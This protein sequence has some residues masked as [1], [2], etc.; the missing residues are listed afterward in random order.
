[1][2][3]TILKG[4]LNGRPRVDRANMAVPDN[5]SEAVSAFK[6]LSQ[7]YGWAISGWFPTD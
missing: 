6:R 1:M 3:V 2:V 7:T 4:L 5:L